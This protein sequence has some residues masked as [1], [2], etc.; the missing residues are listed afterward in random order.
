VHMNVMHRSILESPDPSYCLGWSPCNTPIT[1]SADSSKDFPG[2]PS[3]SMISYNPEIMPLQLN[4]AST[5]NI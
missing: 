3:K 5:I 2:V 4:S 1:H